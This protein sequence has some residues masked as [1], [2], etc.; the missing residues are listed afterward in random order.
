M[1]F[2]IV[3]IIPFILIKIFGMPMIEKKITIEVPQAVKNAFNQKYPAAQMVA[4]E[5]ERIGEFEAEFKLNKKEMSANFLEDGTWVGSEI[6]IEKK[7]LPVTI[8]NSITVKFPDYEIEEA[9]IS[10]KPNGEKLYEVELE[11]GKTKME[12]KAIFSV[13]GS[14]VKKEIE[15]E[16][17]ENDHKD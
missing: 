2:T 3:L 7:D 5:L 13:D 12:F 4:W 11:N 8:K 6:E 9:E 17:E 14:F 10:E 1:K 16:D 15:E